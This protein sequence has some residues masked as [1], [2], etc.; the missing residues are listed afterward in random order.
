[1]INDVCENYILTHMDLKNVFSLLEV[2][3]ELGYERVTSQAVQLICAN[4]GQ[5]SGGLEASNF[6]EFS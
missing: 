6:M 1:M 2:S 4:L 5:G 3:A